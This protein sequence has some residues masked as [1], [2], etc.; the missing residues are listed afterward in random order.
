MGSASTSTKARLD[1]FSKDRDNASALKCF[2]HAAAANI[3][4]DPKT[5]RRTI[6]SIV[7]HKCYEPSPVPLVLAA[8]LAFHQGLA[9]LLKVDLDGDDLLHPSPAQRSGSP[10][11]MEAFFVLAK[12]HALTGQRL[13][14]GHCHLAAH[15][16]SRHEL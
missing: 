12:Q 5:V 6:E 3:S 9:L 16:T 14:P 4:H 15:A 1:L 13:P 8:K 2:F 10:L 7:E 11:S